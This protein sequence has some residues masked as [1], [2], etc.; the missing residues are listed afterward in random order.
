MQ[1][2]CAGKEMQEQ[3][4][5]RVGEKIVFDLLHMIR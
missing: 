1:V 4:G 5:I 2:E 3:M